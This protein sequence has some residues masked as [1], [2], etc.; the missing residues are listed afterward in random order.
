VA[1]NRQRR[2]QQF[3]AAGLR[4]VAEEGLE[5][6]TMSRLAKEVDTAVG[7]VYRYYP[8]KNELVAA[9]QGN[10]IDQ[11][12]RSHDRSVEPVVEALAA[13]PGQRKKAKD[14]PELVR[15]VVLGRWF[16]A[17]SEVYPEEIRLLHLV[18][19]RRGSTMLPETA[20]S[21]LAPTL[22][23]VGVISGAIDAAVAAGE[24]RPGNSLA[25]AILWLTAFGGVFITDD[26][27]MYI[28][29]VLGDRR[30][31]RQLNDDLSVGWGADLGAVERI[32]AAVDA[33]KGDPPLA[34]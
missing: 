14:A 2:S 15:L 29:E 24:L 33:L 10:A 28:P 25:R 19:S 3:L 21:L 23:L 22:A 30:L 13:G 18:G 11:L 20:A 17:A 26:F 31:V 16:V 34:Q 12:H 6:L 8:S 5:A 7:A 9:I 27:D 32:E 1:R 4:I